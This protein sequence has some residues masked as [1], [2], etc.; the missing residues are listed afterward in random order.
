[1]A[2]SGLV[3]GLRQRRRQGAVGIKLGGC[4]TTSLGSACC[5]IESERVLSRQ[6]EAFKKRVWSSHGA[7]HE[8][9]AV[10]DALVPPILPSN[11]YWLVN[12]TCNRLMSEELTE[13]Q[14]VVLRANADVK[15]MGTRNS[16]LGKVKNHRR[17]HRDVDFVQDVLVQPNREAPRY[18]WQ[19]REERNTY[20][21]PLLVEESDKTSESEGV[22]A[23]DDISEVKPKTIVVSRS[24]TTSDEDSEDSD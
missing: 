19:N 18:L 8:L 2:I 6:G 5:S 17:H 21:A 13:M 20:F 10:M 12:G 11:W 3:A 7:F 22:G 1:M 14:R 9:S 15:R 4:R 24:T 23:R 16:L